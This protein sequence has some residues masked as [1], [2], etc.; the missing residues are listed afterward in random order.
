E[1]AA[2]RVL[3]LVSQA[4]SRKARA[5]QF[6]TRFARVYTPVVTGIA[7]VMGLVPSIVADAAT[8]ADWW[9]RA[10]AFLVVSC[11]CALVLSI[12]LAYFAGIGAASRLGV[13]VKG[14]NYLDALSRV[15]DIAFDKTGTL[16]SG[17]MI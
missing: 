15:R 12:P 9:Y 3:A 1:S 2:A 4:Q 10:M 13:L 16:T 7:L 6:M 14:G 17:K 11:P 8:A 5:E